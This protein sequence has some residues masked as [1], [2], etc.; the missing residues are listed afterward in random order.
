MATYKSEFLSHYY[1]GRLRPVTAYAFGL[2]MYWARIAELMPAV[3]NFFTQ[4]PVLRD[5]AK[6]IMGVAPERKIPAFAGQTFRQWFHGRKDGKQTGK[7]VILWADTFNNHLTP[8]PAKAAVE[9]LETAG[10]RVEVPTKRLCCGR[11]LYD[12]G[13]LG[14]AKRLLRQ[15]LDALEDDIAAGVPV[16]GLEPSCIS[17]LR[18]EL[19]N[20]FPHDER[21]RKLS[22]QSFLLSEF[23]VREGYSPGKMTGSAVVHGHCHHKAVMTMR[24]EESLLAGTGLDYQI[25]DSGCCGMAGAFG[26]ENDHYEVSMKVGERVLLPA[27]R[28]ASKEALIVADGF[29]CREQIAQSTDREALHLSQ[30]LLMALKA[31]PGAGEQSEYPERRFAEPEISRLA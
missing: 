8:G 11:P 18:D 17:V 20:L 1:E 13:M 2:I 29:S 15:V 16:V 14:L 26:F 23:L 27:V 31:G 5:L 9:V 6:A 3:A 24:D 30:V 7:R 22:Q 21:A 28:A 12:H 4:A 10:Y 25:L 19:V